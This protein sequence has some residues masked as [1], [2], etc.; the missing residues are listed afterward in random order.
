MLYFSSAKSHRIIFKKTKQNASLQLQ[1]KGWGLEEEEPQISRGVASGPQPERQE[2][3]THFCQSNSALPYRPPA[4]SPIPRGCRPS[5]P[6]PIPNPQ[7]PISNPAVVTVSS[8][9]SGP[10][11]P[12]HQDAPHLLGTPGART[13]SP[14]TAPPGPRGQRHSRPRGDRTV[15]PSPPTTTIAPELSA[16]RF[17]PAPAGPGASAGL[18]ADPR[19]PSPRPCH[20]QIRSPATCPS[21]GR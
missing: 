7:S 16:A 5:R 13:S 4:R 2:T 14:S 10:A 11:T 1:E 3:H 18:P 20:L 12:G 9:P 6:S 8:Y 17:L 15:S 19:L 21:A